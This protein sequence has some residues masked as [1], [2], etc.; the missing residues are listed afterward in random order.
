MSWPYAAAEENR[1]GM[2]GE[3]MQECLAEAMLRHELEKIMGDQARDI[4]V[5]SAGV[6][7]FPGDPASRHAE[8]AMRELGL[9]VSLHR[10]GRVSREAWTAPTLC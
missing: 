3:Y 2:F 1:A 10:A 6:Y 5:T 8:E 9:D 7:A 4:T